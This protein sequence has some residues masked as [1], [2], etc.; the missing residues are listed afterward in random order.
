MSMKPGELF[1]KTL[2][3][4]WAKFL[5]GLVDFVTAVIL[6]ILLALIPN[7][8]WLAI[9]I[10]VVLVVVHIVLW[11]FYGYRLKAGHVA[12]IT[13]FMTGNG[14]NVPKKGMVKYG[15][16]KFQ[17]RGF[18]TRAA[19]FIFDALVGGAVRQL[20]RGVS[21]IGSLAGNN[22]FLKGIFTAINWFLEIVLGSIDECCLAYILINKDVGAFK[23]GAKGVAIFFKNIKTL[24]KSGLVTTIVVILVLVAVTSIFGG[25]AYAI[26]AAA[27]VGSTIAFWYG[28][29]IGGA[30]AAAVK[31]SFIDSYILVR[32]VSAYM[33][34]VPQTE[35]STETYDE[36]SEKSPKFKELNEKAQAE[37][38]AYAV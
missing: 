30:F 17:Q 24:L 1:K 34:C 35:V 9:V 12:V 29:I 33:E 22:R 7:V 15:I 25:I 28:A 19:F 3:F 21:W 32:M 8:A 38:P 23:G 27:G 10:F 11:R 18:L 14:D 4:A 36:L 5:L 2:P 20:Q 6:L 13:E 26:F 31:P 37:E 16:E